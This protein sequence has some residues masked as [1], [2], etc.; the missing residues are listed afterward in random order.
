MGE[1]V[2]AD[3]F[4][5]QLA[6]HELAL[7]PVALARGDVGGDQVAAGGEHH[8]DDLFGDRVGVGAGGVHHVDVMFARIFDVDRIETGPGA[9]DQLELR[10]QVDDFRRDFFA[11]DDQHFGVGV[12][13]DQIG[14][15]SGAVEHHVVSAV[16]QHGGGE[17]VQFSGNQYLAHDDISMIQFLWMF[18]L[19]SYDSLI[20][21]A[22]GCFSTRRAESG[23]EFDQDH[24]AAAVE[25]PAQRLVA[26][27]GAD[28]HARP[29]L[30]AFELAVGE[31]AAV[32]A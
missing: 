23:G 4:A 20:Y 6:A 21:H 1:T 11:A 9:D 13:L 31:G 7:F 24:F 14:E 2:D 26:D 32:P 5:G 19:I 28:D 25:A 16:G 3:G 8:R 12:G 15:R 17:F 10:Q 30:L 22:G 29:E 27:A 18:R